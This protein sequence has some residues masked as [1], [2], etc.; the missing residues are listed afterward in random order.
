MWTVWAY[1]QILIGHFSS[2][3]YFCA[4]LIRNIDYGK[5][6]YCHKRKDPFRSP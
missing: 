6:G 1:F 3:A 2:F 5:A 4:E